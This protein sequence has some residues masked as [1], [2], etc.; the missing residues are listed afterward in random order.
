MT[1]A[2]VACVALG[3]PGVSGIMVGIDHIPAIVTREG[4]PDDFDRYFEEGFRNLSAE[5][6][7]LR[8]FT[9]VREL[10]EDVKTRLR[11]VDGWNHAAIIA[12]DAAARDDDHP[13]GRPVGVARW[14]GRE[15]GPP[16]LS[17]TIIDDYQGQGVGTRLM[18]ALLALARKRGVRRIIADMLRENT[19]MRHLCN[20][21]NA[22]VQPSGDPVVVRYRID[23]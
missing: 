12:F 19:G 4:T 20:R 11:N 8:F 21:Y 15:A 14:I 2:R 10:P 7:H 23:V 1:R 18:D 22:T 16:E 17:V 9:A 6:R 5:S 3:H 13:E